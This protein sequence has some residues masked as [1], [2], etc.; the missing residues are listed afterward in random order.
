MPRKPTWLLG[1][2]RLSVVGGSLA[3]ALFVAAGQQNKN[4]MRGATEQTPSSPGAETYGGVVTDSRCG[5]RHLRDSGLGPAECARRCVRLGA[6]YVLVDG[7]RRYQL[8]GND[9]LLYRL[10]GTRARVNGRRQGE[11]ISVSS[12]SF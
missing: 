3:I 12:A 1:F 7:D 9:Q 6:S 8:E 4:D 10:L 2:C 11:T 5:A